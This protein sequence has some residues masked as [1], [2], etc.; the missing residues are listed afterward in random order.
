MLLEWGIFAVITLDS[1][2]HDYL[3]QILAD[4]SNTGQLNSLCVAFRFTHE[5]W[6][7]IGSAACL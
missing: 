5:C 1:Q 4:I 2:S 6:L 7:D 3:L